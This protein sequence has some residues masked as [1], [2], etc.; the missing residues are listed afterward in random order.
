MSAVG[1]SLVPEAFGLSYVCM[2]QESAIELRK[3]YTQNLEFHFPVSR[4]EE[5][6]PSSPASLIIQGYFLWFHQPERW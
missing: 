1:N 5:F 2:G 4:V 6:F 3:V